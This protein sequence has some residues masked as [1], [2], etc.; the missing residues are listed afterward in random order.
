MATRTN[1]THEWP[2]SPSDMRGGNM[3]T[4]VLLVNLNS[5]LANRLILVAFAE[6]LDLSLE[7]FI[8]FQEE[9]DFH[10]TVDEQGL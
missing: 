8:S 6:L 5:H 1:G 7:L 4:P 9:L 2:I 3:P 10:V